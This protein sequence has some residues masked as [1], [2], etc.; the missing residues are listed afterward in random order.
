MLSRMH[1]KDKDETPKLTPLISPDAFLN[2]FEAGDPGTLEHDTVTAQQRHT[3]IMKQW[4]RT[5]SII[6]SKGPHTTEWR[7]KGGWLVVPLDDTLKR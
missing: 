7:D 4:E 3:K 1:Q 2:I 5:I 6:P